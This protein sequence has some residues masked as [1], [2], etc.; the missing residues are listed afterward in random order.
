M[1]R[2]HVIQAAT[3]ATPGRHAASR[4]LSGHRMSRG[5]AWRPA[6]LFWR[7]KR[8]TAQPL[9]VLTRT[10]ENTVWAPHLHL[11]FNPQASDRSR[12]PASKTPVPGK[13]RS[14]GRH[15]ILHRYHTHVLTIAAASSWVRPSTPLQNFYGRNAV[16]KRGRL[17]LR[18]LPTIPAIVLPTLL[19]RRLHCSEGLIQKGVAS[20]AET[21]FLRM[22]LKVNTTR[23]HHN[24]QELRFRSVAVKGVLGLRADRSVDAQ[25]KRA[26]LPEL[27]WSRPLQRAGDVTERRSDKELTIITPHAVG[28]HHTRDVTADAQPASAT[29]LTKHAATLDPGLMDR[30]ADDVIRRVERRLRIERERRGL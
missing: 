11:H 22:T 24:M 3:L 23:H 28:S 1:K 26:R 17:L 13:T 30:L 18:A 21:T 29:P 5:L 14:S 27:V 2:R 20:R 8:K 10:L 9:C 19:A 25:P 15:S 12:D 7:R 6:V 16:A 4:L